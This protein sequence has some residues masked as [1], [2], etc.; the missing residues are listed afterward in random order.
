MSAAAIQRGSW[1]LMVASLGV[2][3]S[4]SLASAKV[5][6]NNPTAL[7]GLGGD[8]FCHTSPLDR[9]ERLAWRQTFIMQRPGYPFVPAAPFGL[10]VPYAPYVQTGWFWSTP[11][12]GVF[13]P[14]CR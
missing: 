5:V 10:W 7:S 11:P 12:L 13:A 8:G 1:I 14:I 6:W 3:G 9:A 4:A 2:T